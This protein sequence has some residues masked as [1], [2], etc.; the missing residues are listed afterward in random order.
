M[1]S[2]NIIHSYIGVLRDPLLAPRK[3]A[4]FCGP[5]CCPCQGPASRSRAAQFSNAGAQP[6]IS[7]PGASRVGKAV[8]RFRQQIVLGPK[9]RATCCRLPFRLERLLHSCLYH[10]APMR[11]LCVSG[12]KDLTVHGSRAIVSTLCKGRH[13]RVN[14]IGKPLGLTLWI[15]C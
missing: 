7:L 10:T 14:N 13:G 3:P 1:T 6:M 11:C 4:V 12:R 8:D 15:N 5:Q 2:T 9:R